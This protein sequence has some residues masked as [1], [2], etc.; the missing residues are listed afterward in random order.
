MI[1]LVYLCFFGMLLVAIPSC[2]ESPTAEVVD[3]YRDY[4]FPTDSLVPYIYVFSDEKN[5]LD[6]RFLR[7][8]RMQNDTDTSFIVE[9]FNSSL[10]ITEGFTYKLNDSLT[11][12]D[13]MVVDR[14]GLKR[15]TKLSAHHNF[16]VYKNMTAR[17]LTDF[18]G[19]I[20]STVMIKDSKKYIFDADFSYVLFDKEVPAILV[21]DTMRLFELNIETKEMVQNTI[22]LDHVYAK[23]F[24]LVEWGAE[25]KSV[26]YALRKLLS[27]EW[28]SENAQAPQV[29]F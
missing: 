18:P 3:N 15:R 26:V 9:Q 29:R 21:K 4:F 12:I 2:E 19:V 13:H 5:P 16:P 8:Y 6:E 27:D 22:V 28:W 25:D 7:M 24:G 23:G 14:D 10:R 20:D 11:I 17:F 1:K